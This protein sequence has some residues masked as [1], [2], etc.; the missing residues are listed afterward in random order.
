MNVAVAEMR[1]C[2]CHFP[3]KCSFCAAFVQATNIHTVNTFRAINFSV[4]QVL[5]AVGQ[6]VQLSVSLCLN[7][8]P[9]LFFFLLWL[10]DNFMH[11][12]ML[13]FLKKNQLY[14]LH[15]QLS[16]RTCIMNAQFRST[17]RPMSKTQW[18]GPSSMLRLNETRRERCAYLAT[19]STVNL[20][21]IDFY[22]TASSRFLSYVDCFQSC[23][24]CVSG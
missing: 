11:M 7:S 16:C 1:V 8:L 13:H 10:C 4:F 19:T 12:L 6:C 18:S 5:G 3:L 15:Q 9:L 21:K 20:K 23:A 24:Y 14:N 22:I 17:K 2:A